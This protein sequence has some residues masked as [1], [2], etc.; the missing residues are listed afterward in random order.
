[1]DKTGLTLIIAAYILPSIVACVRRHK[2][3][4]AIIV[5]NLFLGWTFVGWVAALVWAV[6]YIERP[7]AS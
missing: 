4:S 1:M 7:K 5:L 2:N 6:S 3:E